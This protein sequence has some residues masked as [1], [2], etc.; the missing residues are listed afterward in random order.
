MAREH[1]DVVSRQWGQSQARL[2]DNHWRW[3][4]EG[5]VRWR[6]LTPSH[7]LKCLEWA[8]AGFFC[9]TQKTEPYYYNQ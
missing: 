4:S 6:R 5:G 2:L 1:Q 8:A 3:M 9:R 7:Y